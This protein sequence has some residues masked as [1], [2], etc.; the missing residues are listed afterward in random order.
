M[1]KSL[2]LAVVLALA[3]PASARGPQPD[4]DR[5]LSPYFLVS[6]EDAAAGKLPL[7]STEAEVSIAGVIADV[8]VTQR[9][10]NAGKRP[11]EAVYIFPA[12][13]RAAVYGMKMTIG[14]RVIVAEVQKRGQAR[15]NYEQALR[16]GRSASLLERQRPNVFQMNVGNILPGDT[17]LVELS[18][19]ELLVPT[20]GVYEFVYPTV[21]GPRYSEKPAQ[22]APDGDRWVENPYLREGEPA[23]YRFDI[24]VRLAAG[25]AIAE[26]TCPS[27]QTSIKY[28]GPATATCRLDPTARNGDNRDFILRYRLAGSKVES[29][30]LL[31]P[32]E[33]E[34]FFLA[35]VQPPRRVAR[36]D[37][38]GREYI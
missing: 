34:N 36:E 37:I 32:G 24:G 6:G 23:P 18:Y 33:K 22:G 17:I 16:E 31:F 7:L 11:I 4:G 30:L 26:M 1:S 13:T 38:P 21:V 28:D 10:H 15:E 2:V 20:D 9:Y 3:L 14:E 12:S 19:T 8:R 29:G 5:T 35:M 25:L 27:H